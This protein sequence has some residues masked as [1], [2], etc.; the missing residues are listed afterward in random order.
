MAQHHG[1]YPCGRLCH[2]CTFR[3]GQPHTFELDLGAGGWTP[4]NCAYCPNVAG[5]F[6][7]AFE[8][9][10]TRANE[11]APCVWTYSV[12]SACTWNLVGIN[13]VAHLYIELKVGAASPWYWELLVSLSDDWY[14]RRS[15]ARYRGPSRTAD[16]C[17]YDLDPAT[18]KITLTKYGAE[19]HDGSVCTGTLPPTVTIEPVYP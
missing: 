2:N 4:V 7:L 8:G 12:G 10:N 18:N 19:N 5:L 13:R 11:Y 3:C 6:D 14:Y 15:I 9:F 16:D 17:L 1:W